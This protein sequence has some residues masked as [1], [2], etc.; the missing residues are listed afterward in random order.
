[1]RHFPI[2]TAGGQAQAPG[3]QQ[4]LTKSDF[5][6]VKR[7]HDYSIKKDNT[8]KA[9]CHHNGWEKNEKHYTAKGK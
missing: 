7:I 6:T 5:G 1:L 2:K 3:R 4:V 8:S 9:H